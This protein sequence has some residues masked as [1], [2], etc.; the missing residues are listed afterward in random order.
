MEKAFFPPKPKRPVS[1]FVLY[2][3]QVQNHFTEE[4]PNIRYSEILKK[5]SKRWAVL[6]PVE[7]E[8][9]QKQYNENYEAYTKELQEYNNSITEEQKQLWEEKKKECK[10]TDTGI[11]NKRVLVLIYQ[12]NASLFYSPN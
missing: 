9:F 6:D 8:H 7:K 12:Y 5:A 3:K 10:Q 4:E 11:N 2:V 1:P